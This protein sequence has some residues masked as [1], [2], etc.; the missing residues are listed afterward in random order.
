MVRWELYAWRVGIADAARADLLHLMLQR[1]PA[2]RITLEGIGRHPWLQGPH[3]PDP[4]PPPRSPAPAEQPAKKPRG[5]E[6]LTAG[7]GS[8]R[9]SQGSAGVAGVD[10]EDGVQPCC[11]TPRGG[12]AKPPLHRRDTAAGG[13]AARQAPKWPRWMALNQGTAP[14][15][16]SAA[17]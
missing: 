11:L 16:A 13:D 1:K 5:L 4:V 12:A 15:A 2:A 17:K 7:L 3:A 6:K 14:A 10:D 9:V 8:M